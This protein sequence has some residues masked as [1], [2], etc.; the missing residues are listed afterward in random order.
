MQRAAKIDTVQPAIREALEKIGATVQSLG[1]VGDGFFDLVAGFRGVNVLLECKT[2][3]EQP[4]ARQLERH[5]T[6]NGQG[7]VVRTPEEATLEVIRIA[8]ALD[9]I[10]KL[11]EALGLGIHI[12]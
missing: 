11:R 8:T 12:P 2:G 1:Q 7:S 9:A 5:A 4:S 3:N 6:W 10:G